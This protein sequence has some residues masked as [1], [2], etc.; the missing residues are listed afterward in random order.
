MFS[1]SFS[2]G[3]PVNNLS[4]STGTTCL[5]VSTESTLTV[6]MTQWH[7]DNSE[8]YQQKAHGYPTRF[9]QSIMPI[10]SLLCRYLSPLSTPPIT[11]N[12]KKGFKNS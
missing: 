2:W 11:T 3:L 9:T 7:G 4:K 8:L 5:N 6:C 1:T 10:Y 12:E